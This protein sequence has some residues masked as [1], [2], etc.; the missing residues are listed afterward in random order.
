M[1]QNRILKCEFDFYNKN[2]GVIPNEN[3]KKS[4]HALRVL[5]LRLGSWRKRT[6][7]EF[8]GHQAKR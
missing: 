7:L 6:M 1:T 3:E 5:P 2:E 4:L 8:S